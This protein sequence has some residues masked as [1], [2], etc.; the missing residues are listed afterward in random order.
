MKKEE[1]GDGAVSQAP[2][3]K[4]WPVADLRVQSNSSPRNAE[5]T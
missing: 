3:R 1:D 4:N 5:V 2:G